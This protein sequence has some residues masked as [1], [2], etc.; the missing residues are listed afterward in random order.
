VDWVEALAVLTAGT[1]AGAINTV[2][3]SGSLIT[4]PV[5]LALG[6]SPVTANVSNNIGLVPG[7]IS[8][9]WGYRRELAGQSGRIRVLVPLAGAGA[10]AG[11]GLL[12]V[13][14]AAAF[15]N[16]VPVLLVV[17]LVLVAVQPR[18]QARIRARAET[19]RRR[20]PVGADR[21]VLLAGTFAAG[22]YGGY[23]GAA[24]GV[25][26]MG[27]L[28]SVLPDPPHRLNAL[29]NAL[30]LTANSLAALVFL[31]VAHRQVDFA[32]AALIA[33]GSVVGGLVGARYGRR[34]PPTALRVTIIAVG[35]L[36]IGRLLS[37]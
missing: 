36:A 16:V 1:A 7:G 26:L 11:A 2:V 24:Q 10:V 15:R 9:T 34:I 37:G 33:A 32:A 5:L 6:L 35:V 14:P 19:Q 31:G 3:G 22:T 30:A 17:S 12:L 8:G 4:F 23:F 18:L 20:E 27:L 28:G 29:K 25:L 21:H 13:L